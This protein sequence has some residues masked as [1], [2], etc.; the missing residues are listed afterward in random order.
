M[1]NKILKTIAILCLPIVAE[2]QTMYNNGA[3]L[4]VNTGATLQVNGSV[5]NKAGSNYQNKGTVYITGDFENNQSNFN[6]STQWTGNVQMLYNFDKNLKDGFPERLMMR[7]GVQYKLRV[8][9]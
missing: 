4:F 2:A 9:S 5:K 3:S 1:N 8:K 7:I 6:I